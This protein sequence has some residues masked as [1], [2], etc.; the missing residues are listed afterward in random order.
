MILSIRGS[1]GVLDPGQGSVSG[2]NQVRGISIQVGVL[3]LKR[4]FCGTL[5][6]EF[7]VTVS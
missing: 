6:C 4:V 1:T 2:T 7:I 5:Q 3:L